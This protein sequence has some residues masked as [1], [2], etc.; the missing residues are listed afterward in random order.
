[1]EG[2][3]EASGAADT[4]SHDAFT[5]VRQIGEGAY[6]KVYLIKSNVTQELVCAHP[7]LRATSHIS[8]LVST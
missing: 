6:G 1:M 3:D 7:Q 4:H 5:R 8:F 2:G